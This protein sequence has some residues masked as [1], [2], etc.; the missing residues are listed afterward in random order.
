MTGRDQRKSPNI[1]EW[2]PGMQIS[3]AGQQAKQLCWQNA[4]PK[5]RRRN[6][7]DGA[8]HLSKVAANDPSVFQLSPRKL[9]LGNMVGAAQLKTQISSSGEKTKRS[10]TSSKKRLSKK[11]IISGDMARSSKHNHSSVGALANPKG[12]LGVSELPI[13]QLLASTVKTTSPKMKSTSGKGGKH[14]GKPNFK[15]TSSTSKKKKLCEKKTSASC[16]KNPS[17]RRGKAAAASVNPGSYPNGSGSAFL[18]HLNF[19]PIQVD[20]EN[21]KGDDL[22][23]DGTESVPNAKNVNYES[24]MESNVSASSSFT[25]MAEMDV[26]SVELDAGEDLKNNSDKWD[27]VKPHS[28][29][30]SSKRSQGD[31]NEISDSHHPASALQHSTSPKSREGRGGG[32]ATRGRS[33]TP[34]VSHALKLQSPPSSGCCSNECNTDQASS[35]H[36]SSTSA[37]DTLSQAFVAL[38]D[39]SR[40][41]VQQEFEQRL[42]KYISMLCGENADPAAFKRLQS[43]I[44]RQKHR[45][46]LSHIWAEL[47]SKFA[48]KSNAGL[49]NRKSEPVVA[50]ATTDDS[51]SK[52]GTSPVAESKQQNISANKREDNNPAAYVGLPP[53]SR[54]PH[55]TDLTNPV[56]RMPTPSLRYLLKCAIS[57]DPARGSA[58]KKVETSIENRLVVSKLGSAI[59]DNA[60]VAKTCQSNEKQGVRE[61]KPPAWIP[62]LQTNNGAQTDGTGCN[63]DCRSRSR[64]PSVVSGPYLTTTRSPAFTGL[65]NLVV[66]ADQQQDYAE[67]SYLMS[68]T[69]STSSA[70]PPSYGKLSPTSNFI[71]VG[72][73]SSTGN[74]SRGCASHDG[75]TSSPVGIKRTSSLRE[76]PKASPKN[77]PRPPPTP[78]DFRDG[79][80]TEDVSARVEADLQKYNAVMNRCRALLG[81]HEL[82][83]QESSTWTNSS[84]VTAA[85]AAAVANTQIEREIRLMAG[86]LVADAPGKYFNT[87]DQRAVVNQSMGDNFADPKDHRARENPIF[88]ESNPKK[89]DGSV[90]ELKKLRRSSSA[91]GPKAETTNLCSLPPKRSS[92]NPY[93][94]GVVDFGSV[95][96]IKRL[97]DPAS[98]QGKPKVTFEIDNEKGMLS[99]PSGA[100]DTA[101]L[102]S[103]HGG[104]ASVP[105]STEPMSIDQAVSLCAKKTTSGRKKRAAIKSSG[106]S[107][108]RSKHKQ[109]V[110]KSAPTK[111]AGLAITQGEAK[112]A[113]SRKLTTINEGCI[114][115]LPLRINPYYRLDLKGKPLITS[116]APPRPGSQTSWK[117]VDTDGTLRSPPPV[118]KNTARAGKP[119]KKKVKRVKKTS[120]VLG[121]IPESSSGQLEKVTNKKA[122]KKPAQEAKTP[123]REK[124]RTPVR[125]KE[126]I[127][128]DL[129]QTQDT[130]SDPETCVQAIQ[131]AVAAE[132]VNG[133][134]DQISSL[135]LQDEET[136]Q[137]SIPSS[138]A[139][140]SNTRFSPHKQRSVSF[141]MLKSSV[142]GNQPNNKPV[143]AHSLSKASCSGLGSITKSPS[144]STAVKRYGY[145]PMRTPGRAQQKQPVSARSSDVS[146]EADTTASEDEL[147]RCRRAFAS[148]KDSHPELEKSLDAWPQNT[149]TTVLRKAGPLVVALL[150][151]WLIQYNYAQA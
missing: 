120:E 105:A 52:A 109:A 68:Q 53:P 45:A 91:Q 72:K 65:S 142:P 114:S 97:V 39:V 78:Q 95:A 73:Q 94:V 108:K 86:E 140:K 126:A 122:A 1:L 49:A 119:P 136:K 24:W 98:C 43:R 134:D 102:L 144:K 96:A 103:Q 62:V 75:K 83:E 138:V 8:A 115:R 90:K 113:L 63:C 101:H 124:E 69:G 46:S 58:K 123:V 47:A 150:I 15:I 89:D 34:H 111:G 141:G 16:K 71:S 129:G 84:C 12:F 104:G 99:I 27:A 54:R 80:F 29:R 66:A 88:S 6:T 41:R 26:S 21:T 106:K 77:I 118:T 4:V 135:S 7:E 117:T 133:E 67:V 5:R 81:E 44:L 3:V 112:P 25:S 57:S 19:R 125:E 50:S 64:T 40:E 61:N 14:H 48:Q 42:G 76:T 37:S 13:S 70:T 20:E 18:R 35:S 11:R 149:K 9:L 131:N 116:P 143:A 32:S 147:E 2:L 128:I 107:G 38:D 17:K 110:A 31:I 56:R 55:S 151:Q 60:C 93:Y 79:D 132:T 127:K 87:G 74:L 23:L 130:T 137:A 10:K 145:R 100:V 148:Y 30:A 82:E 139:S 85:A 33:A 28:R 121:E 92:S 36:V 146:V 51:T 22:G 59:G